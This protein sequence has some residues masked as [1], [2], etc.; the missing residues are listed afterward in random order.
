MLYYELRLLYELKQQYF[1]SFVI[2]CI[3]MTYKG[4]L[5]FFAVMLIFDYRIFKSRL[6]TFNYIIKL[7]ALVVKYSFVVG[8]LTLYD[9]EH[10]YF[11]TFSICLLEIYFK[12]IYIAF[13]KYLKGSHLQRKLKIAKFFKENEDEE[14]LVK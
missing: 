14:V 10:R 11:Q 8:L 3:A 1:L 7:T 13:V 4:V 12:V 9:S 6:E 5:L 2:T